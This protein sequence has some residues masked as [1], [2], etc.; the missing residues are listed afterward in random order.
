M[1]IR[2]GGRILHL[3]KY[4]GSMLKGGVVALYLAV[5]TAS[6]LTAIDRYNVMQM[7]LSLTDAVAG[8]NTALGAILIAI[9]MGTGA[10]C[11]LGGVNWAGGC[12]GPG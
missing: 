8:H 3:L 1:S 11:A 12:R 10:R 4:Y 5:H 7:G 6:L 9:L 2:L